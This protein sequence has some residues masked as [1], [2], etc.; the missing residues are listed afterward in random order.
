MEIIYNKT[1]HTRWLDSVN[2]RFGKP[3]Q[4]ELIVL[5]GYMSS[6]KTEFSYFVARENIK[7]WNKV[8]YISLELPE[9]DMKLRIAR[10][11]AGVSKIDF[12][13]WHITPYQKDLMNAN[14]KD[15]DNTEWLY[16]IKPDDCGLWDIEKTIHEYYDKWC[17]MFIVDNLD[18][19]SWKENDNARYQEI[20]SLLQ[21]TKNNLWI[22]IILIHHAKKPFNKQQQY[23]PAGMSWL[24]W[25]Q[26]ILDNATQVIEIWRD[27]DPETEDPE[28]KA[29]V[30]LHQYKDTFEWANGYIDIYFDKWSYKDVYEDEI[31]TD[32]N[33][34][35][36]PDREWTG[37]VHN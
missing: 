37:T 11:S 32:V 29:L 25:S 3:D 22:N 36:V 21:D 2:N 20:S 33:N 18:K 5:F 35:S 12:Q 10:K 4:R 19:I 28:M 16:I 14:F 7:L 6:G 26:K 34:D 30:Q 23:T 27:L 8:C 1:P 17:R 9:Y 13:N 31:S 24:R 15:L